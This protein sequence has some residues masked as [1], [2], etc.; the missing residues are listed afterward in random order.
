LKRIKENQQVLRHFEN[1]SRQSNNIVIFSKSRTNTNSADDDKSKQLD[2]K[3]KGFDKKVKEVI[4]Q[5]IDFIDSEILS[6][7][8]NVS[9]DDIAGLDF[10]KKTIKEI[11]IW[12]LL[13][14]DIF[15]G[16]LRP[17]KVVLYNIRVCY[18]S[19][20]LEQVRQ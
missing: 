17:P 5:L 2:Q 16:I 9:W 8:P 19:A 11:I 7:S 14:P 12:P 10:A 18:F 4:I 13:R 6:S 1:S 15:N 20:H 3:L